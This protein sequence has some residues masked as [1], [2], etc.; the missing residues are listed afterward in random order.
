MLAIPAAQ[1]PAAQTMSMLAFAIPQHDAA[2]ASRRLTA[3]ASAPPK[4]IPSETVFLMGRL[5]EH[6]AAA[7]ARARK[8]HARAYRKVR[9]R[10]KKLRMK[11][12]EPAVDRAPALADAPP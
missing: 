8:F 11:F 4:G 7:A 2:V 6:H 5:A 10:W 9:G 1:L 12:K 3:L